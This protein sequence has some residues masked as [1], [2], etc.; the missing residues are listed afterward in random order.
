MKGTKELLYVTWS[1]EEEENGCVSFLVPEY[2]H[3]TGDGRVARHGLGRQVIVAV[4][5]V[6]E[7]LPPLA[8]WKVGLEDETRAWTGHGIQWTPS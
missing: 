5:A 8:V 7:G 3:V 4:R 6:E 1:A 2:S